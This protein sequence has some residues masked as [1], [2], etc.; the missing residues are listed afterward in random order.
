[1]VRYFA[2]DATHTLRPFVS[3][4]PPLR[5]FAVDGGKNKYD[6]ADEFILYPRCV[7]RF[8]SRKAQ[9]IR[10]TDSPFFRTLAFYIFGYD[11]QHD[12]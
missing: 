6:I 3:P 12:V 2:L 4:L 5:T 1:V 9:S 8:V 7:L 10:G 11:G